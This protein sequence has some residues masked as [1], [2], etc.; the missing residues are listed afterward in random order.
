[1][2]EEKKKQDEHTAH[3][4]TSDT[5]TISNRV[6][7][8]VE[9]T[10]FYTYQEERKLLRK[11]DFHL[12]PLLILLYLFKNLDVNNVS[13]LPTLNTGTNSNILTELNMTKDDWSWV[14]TIYFIPFVIFEIP[15]TMLLKKTTPRVHQFRIASLWGATT[16]CQAAVRNKQG[17][18]ALRFL[19]GMFEAGLYPSQLTHLT[20]WY[21]PDEITTRMAFLG[22][23]GSFSN[24]LTSFIT[25]G[26][27]FASG[28]H[29]LS[30]W[31]WVFLIEGVLTVAISFVILFFLPNFPENPTWLTE[32]EKAF[33]LARLPPSSPKSTDK[34]LNWDDIVDALRRPTLLLFSFLRLFQSLGTYGLAFWLP[35][36]IQKFGITS[37]ATAPLLTAPSAAISVISGILFSYAVDRAVVKPQ[38]IVLFSLSASFVSFL[39][40]MLVKNSAVLY[41][42]I[43]IATLAA[44]A[45]GSVF[46][47]WMNQTLKGSTE[48]GFSMAF[49][50]TIGQ[51]GGII[52]PQ[53]FRSRY[54]PRYT[55]PYAVCLI[56][57][58]IGL[59]TTFFLWK[60]TSAIV[61]KTFVERK[62]R[63]K[64]RAGNL[65]RKPVYNSKAVAGDVV[66]FKV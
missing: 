31:Q 2:T 15:S 55:I 1:M 62:E 32:E 46:S 50:N 16:A 10:G 54:A 48:V 23:L 22:V 6:R 30:A 66:E 44:S 49:A 53:I 11:V 29:G 65:T 57:I 52:G 24:F 39:V 25:Y 40:L 56:F 27:S 37:A 19:L 20:Y 14:G 64:D 5:E 21:R 43:I 38:Y 34:N 63:L 18:W 9:T 3:D 41:A 13:Y 59:F 26:F 17:L 58:G 42:F 60:L 51:L 61:S 47:S 28:H 36:I 8:F 7:E 4:V 33:L 45:D 12:M 35:S